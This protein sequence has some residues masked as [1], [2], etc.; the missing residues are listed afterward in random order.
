MYETILVPL[1]GSERAEQILPHAREMATKFGA[2]LTL[3]RVTVPVTHMASLEAPGYGQIILDEMKRQ[4]QEAH[5]YLEDIR[6]NLE[7][8]GLNT[9]SRVERGQPVE[10]ILAVAEE[11]GIDLIAMSSQGRTGLPRVLFGS[12][13]AGVLHGTDRP[14]LLIR[15]QENRE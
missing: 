7:G 9:K 4:N 11:D 12:V 10:R 15:S 13:A 2:T 5:A 3:L 8:H 1:D 6:Q 14:L